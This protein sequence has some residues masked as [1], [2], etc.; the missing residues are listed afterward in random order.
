M[1]TRMLSDFAWSI[2]Y[3]SL[4]P[5][6]INLAKMCMLD[7]MGVTIAGCEKEEANIWRQYY[8]LPSASKKATA[9][10]PSFPD[11]HYQNAAAFNAACGHLLDMDDVHN[12]SIAH[13]GVVTIPAAVAIGQALHKSGRDVLSAIVSGYEVGARIGE[14]LNPASYWFWHTTGIVGTFS[15]GI[16]AGKLMELSKE[17]LL[18]TL[19]SAGTQSAGLWAFLKDGAMS[20]PLHTSHA[21]LSGIRSAE[22][23]SLGLTSSTQILEDERGLIKALAP[24][25]RL[26]ILTDDLCHPYKIETN[27]LKPYACC[28]HTHSACYGITKLLES[29][30]FDLS[31]ISHIIDRTYRAAVELT[32]NPNPSTPYAG[33]FSLQYCIAAAFV[34][35]DLSD[36]SF[37]L[38]NLQNPLIQNIIN[39]IQ[40]IID[41][42]LEEENRRRPDQWSH[43]I[44]VFMADGAMHEIRIDFPLGD[45]RNPFT[46]ETAIDKFFTLTNTSLSHEQQKKLV[47][48]IQEAEQLPDINQLFE[49]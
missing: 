14:A 20:K 40:I 4:P 29:H 42:T 47:S 9:W 27:S 45:F 41:G 44:Q 23:S 36:S 11:S 15:A 32:D 30:S 39:K 34:F 28:R 25:S 1:Y 13:L 31:Q 6:V 43:W 33:K 38:S 22:L 37:T 48:K 46:W 16:A 26:E 49:I 18:Y 19:G 35:K 2:R 3:E 17:Q 10:T 21:V 5:G 7:L 24:Q 8:L 12:A